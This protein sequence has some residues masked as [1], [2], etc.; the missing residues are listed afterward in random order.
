MRRRSRLLFPL[1]GAALT[2]AGFEPSAAAEDGPLG[3]LEVHERWTGL[4]EDTEA[5]FEELVTERRAA[6]A[7]KQRLGLPQ[8]GTSNPFEL[9]KLLSEEDEGS[10]PMTIASHDARYARRKA[11]IWREEIAAYAAGRSLSE[12]AIGLLH[13]FADAKRGDETDW[14]RRL[15]RSALRLLGTEVTDPVVKAFLA[16]ETIRSNFSRAGKVA[17]AKTLAVA[18]DAAIAADAPPLFRARLAFY[19]VRQAKQ[20]AGGG[21]QASEDDPLSVP[22]RVKIAAE[23]LGALSR[24]ITPEAAAAR[25]Q[26]PRLAYELALET[27]ELFDPAKPEEAPHRLVLLGGLSKAAEAGGDAYAFHVLMT[28]FLKDSGW[29]ARGTGMASSVTDEGWE[30]FHERLEAAAEHGHAAWTLH[31]HLP[32]APTLMIVVTMG[33]G[34]LVSEPE[35]FAETMKAQLDVKAAWITTSRSLAPRWGGSQE[36]RLL[37]ARS[38]LR[39]DLREA[40]VLWRGF[41]ILDNVRVGGRFSDGPPPEGPWRD[42]LA[43]YAAHLVEFPPR[44]RR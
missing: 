5:E 18:V 11:G 32:Q 38:A 39:E 24:S 2:I 6:A 21:D 3:L 16:R 31:P 35:W 42:A 33:G 19:A 34:D 26:L 8:L 12:D 15:K 43:A 10:K 36:A 40:D 28:T 20:R 22:L 29:K 13:G 9:P 30:I 17:D 41:E 44:R 14:D 7:R 25:P 4:L 23:Q 1:L 37:L 27:F